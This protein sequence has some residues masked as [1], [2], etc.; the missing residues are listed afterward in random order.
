MDRMHGNHLCRE[1]PASDKYTLV[2]GTHRCWCMRGGMSAYQGP[3]HTWCSSQGCALH[4]VQPNT[5]S[6]QLHY[7]NHS[8]CQ[9]Q[10][11]CIK[12]CDGRLRGPWL[13]AQPL[14][15]RQASGPHASLV[16]LY[17]RAVGL[18]DAWPS[19]AAW[20]LRTQ[21]C[22]WQLRFCSICARGKAWKWWLWQHQQLSE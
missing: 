2:Q 9:L 3:R 16:P 15:C 11:G 4:R 7:G 19:R 21:P 17:F 10:R 18:S 22:A 6:F 8:R 13:A 1:I 5:T 12:P 14:L 20:P